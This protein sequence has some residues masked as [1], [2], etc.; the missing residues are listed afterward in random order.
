M[1]NKDTILDVTN[2]LHKSLEKTEEMCGDLLHGSPGENTVHFRVLHNQHTIMRS[3][4]LLILM[5]TDLG[6][7][8]AGLARATKALAEAIPGMTKT[9]L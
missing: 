7:E 5:L 4:H 9:D 8:L 3:D 1:I 2:N 6:L